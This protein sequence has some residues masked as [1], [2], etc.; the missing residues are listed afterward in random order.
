MTSM[1]WQRREALTPTFYQICLCLCLIPALQLL[2][3]SVME[4]IK[5]LCQLSHCVIKH[6]AIR[7]VASPRVAKNNT[8]VQLGVLQRMFPSKVNLY[9]CN[10]TLLLSSFP[11]PLLWYSRSHLTGPVLT[12]ITLTQKPFI[13][14]TFH[15]TPFQTVNIVSDYWYT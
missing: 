11:P 3:A 12:A 1:V 14:T 8:D 4:V 15:V 10:L 13:I 7:C 9:I 2:T 6:L 5:L